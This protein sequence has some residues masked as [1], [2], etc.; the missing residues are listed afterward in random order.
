MKSAA[1]NW[2]QGFTVIFDMIKLIDGFKLHFNMGLMDCFSWCTIAP[3]TQRKLV[4]T[5]E[6]QLNLF[7]PYPFL[8]QHKKIAV[9]SVV[10]QTVFGE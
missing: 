9:G 2:G 10:T 7:E 5:P 3:Q 4:E 6:I 8:T 1:L